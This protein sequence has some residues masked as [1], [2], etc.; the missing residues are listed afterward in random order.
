M[1]I[2]FGLVNVDFG[3]KKSILGWEFQ[4]VQGLKLH[5]D[6]T[7]ERGHRRGLSSED[8][9]YDQSSSWAAAY[10]TVAAGAALAAGLGVLVYLK[11]NSN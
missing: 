2:L 11:R 3:L 6:Y 4:M 7:E 9:D 10:K 5:L 8:M 1:F